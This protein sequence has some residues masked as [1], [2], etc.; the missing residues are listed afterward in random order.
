[1][2]RGLTRAQAHQP[3]EPTDRE[4]AV[5]DNATRDTPHGQSVHCLRALTRSSL[6]ARSG[7]P[8]RAREFEQLRLDYLG[9]GSHEEGA[10]TL[11][12][13]RGSRWY[14]TV[15]VE[16][17]HILIGVGVN[18]QCYVYGSS[19]LCILR[20]VA[21]LGCSAGRYSMRNPAR[22]DIADTVIHPAASVE[23]TWA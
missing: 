11:S 3:E 20:G 1:V 21:V 16:R 15:Q 7:I 22:H 17:V 2:T 6:T 9:K 23:T 10:Y 19:R 4:A 5:C 13:W 12:S 18:S 14:G 8:R